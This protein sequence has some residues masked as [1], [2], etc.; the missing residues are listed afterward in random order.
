MTKFCTDVLTD[1]LDSHVGNVITSYFLLAV[2][3]VI[4]TAKNATSNGLGSNF[5]IMVKMRIT[6]FYTIGLT[7]PLDVISLAVS[8]QVQNAFKYCTKVR[9]TSPV[10]QRVESFGHCLT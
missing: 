8:G 6:K 3:N 7:V 4:K 1:V 5:S 9:K 10:G 2:T